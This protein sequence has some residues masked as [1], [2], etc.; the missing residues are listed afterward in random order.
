MKC[1]ISLCLEIAA[2]SQPVWKHLKS[3][4]TYRKIYHVSKRTSHIMNVCATNFAPIS[5]PKFLQQYASVFLNTEKK[6]GLFLWPT[7]QIQ[8]P[9]LL[10][11][12]CAAP[13][14]FDV[15]SQSCFWLL[16]P[17]YDS[18]IHSHPEFNTPTKWKSVV[19]H[20]CEMGKCIRCEVHIFIP[21]YCLAKSNYLEEQFKSP[22]HSHKQ[23]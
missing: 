13:G 1:N 19:K 10:S 17:I 11:C 16:C 7:F 22:K 4:T 20:E 5:K 18:T 8:P 15:T 9:F 12:Y 21:I 23:S 2:S 14:T 6:T 3:I